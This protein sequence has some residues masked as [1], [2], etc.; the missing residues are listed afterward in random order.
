MTAHDPLCLVA[1]G[2]DAFAIDSDSTKEVISDS[3]AFIIPL[4]KR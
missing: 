2:Y 1:G 4:G 3:S